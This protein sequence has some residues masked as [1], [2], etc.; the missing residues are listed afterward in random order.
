MWT[1]IGMVALLALC[2]WGY[3]VSGRKSAE[4]ERKHGPWWNRD[5]C[6]EK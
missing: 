5:E 6:D 1:T 4:W 3:R 2:V